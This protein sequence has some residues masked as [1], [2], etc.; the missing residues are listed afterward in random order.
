MI[1]HACRLSRTNANG[2]VWVCECGAIGDVVPMVGV[3][4]QAPTRSQRRVELT[5][6]IA[7]ARHGSHLEQVRAD[8]A[9]ASDAE[10]AR[11]GK[12]IPF[13]NATLQRRG[14]WG[15]S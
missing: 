8:I 3:T 12:L 14:R 15:H 10:L 2:V 1:G 4:S 13:A 9:R 6:G 11:I 7:R 5:E